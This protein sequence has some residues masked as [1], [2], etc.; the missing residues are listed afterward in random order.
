MDLKR[1]LIYHGGKQIK[2]ISLGASNKLYEWKI[3][4][5][6]LGPPVTV[7]YTTYNRNDTTLTKWESS[8]IPGKNGSKLL[9]AKSNYV[10]GNPVGDTFDNFETIVKRPV[11]AVNTNGTRPIS[12]L[13][14]SETVKILSYAATKEHPLKRRMVFTD[15]KFPINTKAFVTFR[16]IDGGLNNSNVTGKVRFKH[17]SSNMVGAEGFTAIVDKTDVDSSGNP[18]CVVI[19]SMNSA[20]TTHFADYIDL[21]FDQSISNIYNI[22]VYFDKGEQLQILVTGVPVVYRTAYPS[23][24]YRFPFTKAIDSNKQYL[25]KTRAKTTQSIQVALTRVDTQSRIAIGTI[26]IGNTEGITVSG[27]KLIRTSYQD[28]LSTQYGSKDGTL[29]VALYLEAYELV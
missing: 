10:N 19:A 28:G 5:V 8:K 26:P 29:S 14:K 12:D 1:S 4:N 13:K 7:P 17:A 23:D 16:V 25:I 2:Q 6:V 20:A 21:F 24:Y 3:G 15:Y 27:S 11:R 9:Q 22:N 18:L